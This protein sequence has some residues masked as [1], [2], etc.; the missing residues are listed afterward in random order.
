MNP[1]L[2]SLLFTVLVDQHWF[3]LV[4]VGSQVALVC[5]V[6]ALL[7]IWWVEWKGGRVW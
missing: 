1:M 4:L 2:T 6:F 7:V 5:S 3:G